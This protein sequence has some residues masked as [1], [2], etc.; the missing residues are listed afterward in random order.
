M[1]V[2]KLNFKAMRW[3]WENGIRVL[4][5]PIDNA[6]RILKIIVERNKNQELGEK[7]Y[8][9]STVYS[10]INELYTYFFEKEKKEL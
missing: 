9:N 2:L 7:T 1:A 10:K 5:K 4:P 3:C 6:G 8:T